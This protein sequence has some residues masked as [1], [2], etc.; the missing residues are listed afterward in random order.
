MI[1]FIGVI[2]LTSVSYAADIYLAWEPP[3]TNVDGTELTDLA[4]YR[5]YHGTAAGE[6]DTPI[7]VENPSYV[8][9]GLEGGTHYF[10]VTAFD[11]S[12]NESGYSNTVSGTVGPLELTGYCVDDKC[13]I[14][15]SIRLK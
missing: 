13:V 11:T 15:Q 2:S 9:E 7:M 6:Y 12:N 8:F 4:G 5:V 3:T 10:A 1:S 14:E